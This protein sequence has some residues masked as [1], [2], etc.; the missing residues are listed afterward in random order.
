MPFEN[1]SAVAKMKLDPDQFGFYAEE[2]GQVLKKLCLKTVA[3]CPA[4]DSPHSFPCTSSET[5]VAQQ[6][7]VPSAPIREKR[8]TAVLMK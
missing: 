3:I 5:L 2:P 7:M 6:V 8:L 4:F 1:L